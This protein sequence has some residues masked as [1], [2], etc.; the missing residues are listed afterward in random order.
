MLCTAH[1]A[2]LHNNIMSVQCN[3]LSTTHYRDVERCLCLKIE[4]HFCETITF[5][6]CPACCVTLV[7]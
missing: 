2:L 1:R 5:R 7:K 4:G 3:V 6:V